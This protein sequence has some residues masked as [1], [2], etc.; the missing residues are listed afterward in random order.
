MATSNLFLF[1]LN[2]GTASKK[3]GQLRYVVDEVL[4]DD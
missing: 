2:M 4:K 3:V 1:P